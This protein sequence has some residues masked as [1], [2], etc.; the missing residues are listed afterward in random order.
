M[1]IA[2]DVPQVFSLPDPSGP[3]V[4]GESLRG[5]SYRLRGDR[6][7][8]TLGNLLAVRGLD[9]N[10]DRFLY[11]SLAD[12][13]PDPSSLIDLDQ[14][15]VR[16]GDAIQWGESIVIFGDY[17]VD[18][19]S[20]SAILGRWLTAV[21]AKFSV[22]IPDRMKE[23]YG[24]SVPAFK[25]AVSEGQSLILCV[26]CGT[27]ANEPIQMAK[28]EGIDVIV[29]DHHKPQGTLPD[30]VAIINPHRADC[31]SG[32]TMLCAAALAFMLAVGTQ[33]ELRR[34]KFFEGDE[35]RLKSLL[36][37]V[38]LATVADVVPLVETSRLFT[39]KGLEVIKEE[40]SIAMA[41]LM[42]AARVTDVSAGMIGFALGPRINAAGRLGGGSMAEDG[43]LGVKLLLSSNPVEAKDL[44]SRLDVLNAE[45]Q[46][47]EK[48]CLDEA[49][50]AAQEQVDAGRRAIVI[51]G[52]G[53]HP[54]V[55]GIVASRIK[56]RYNRPTIVGGIVDGM[57]KASGRSVQGFD[58]GAVVIEARSRGMLAAGG[59]HAMACGVTC[60]VAEWG[61]FG[62]FLEKRTIYEA[63][64]L[65]VDLVA[66]PEDLTVERIEELALLQPLGQG[67]PAVRVVV[68]D[69]L[70][71]SI[72]ELKNGHVK[73]SFKSQAGGFDGMWWRAEADGYLDRLKALVGSRVT[74]IATPDVNE[75][76]GRKSPQLELHDLLV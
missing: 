18:G 52:E 29:V 13:M 66:A 43:A 5:R 74:V 51:A 33:R 10:P 68:A 4:A 2:E 57:I 44:A 62:A 72:R 14:A 50:K 65:P 40:P 19:A 15:A 46:A 69:L 3:M 56:E 26:D 64:S 37:L 34:R 20:A 23:G 9:G 21:G 11:P 41:A 63:A 17:D 42:E 45:R 61:S 32:L 48:T 71:D 30:A 8:L 7:G 1:S 27:A 6:S 58:L 73:I 47:I 24:P 76:N 28:D 75:W 36:E 60:S 54:G 12:D 67:M 70:V 39:A 31:T 22:Y 16:L 59:G 53:W 38:A 55:V 49:E 25:R 35:P